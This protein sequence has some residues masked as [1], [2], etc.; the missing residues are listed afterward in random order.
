MKRMTLVFTADPGGHVSM[1]LVQ[2]TNT[3][4]A[5]TASNAS[6]QIEKVLFICHPPSFRT[7]NARATE[8]ERLFYHVP[9][10]A[11][12]LQQITSSGAR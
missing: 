3:G 5:A 8:V 9:V 10:P 12:W 1:F 11:L 2:P 6:K 4:I 7:G